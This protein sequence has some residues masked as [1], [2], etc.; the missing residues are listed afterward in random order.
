MKT[1]FVVERMRAFSQGGKPLSVMARERLEKL[2]EEIKSASLIVLN[3][4]PKGPRDQEAFLQKIWELDDTLK[5]KGFNSMSPKWREDVADFYK[6]G[7][8][9]GVFRKGRQVGA[10]KIVAPR[11]AVCEALYGGHRVPPGERASIVFISVKRGEAQKRAGNITAILDAL[12]VKYDQAG[13]T[14]SLR[15]RA[16]DFIVLTASLRTSVGDTAIMIWCDEVSRWRDADTGANP[17]KQILSTVRPMIVTMPDARMWLVSSPL[18]K[19]DAHF[20]AYEAGDS[21][22]QRCYFGETWT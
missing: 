18:G 21:D 14:I 20:E 1:G 4:Q 2:N 10:S 11:I 6:S 15:D 19:T 8:R 5:A 13:D 17:A 3:D 16:I 7:R 9:Q 22:F 12:G